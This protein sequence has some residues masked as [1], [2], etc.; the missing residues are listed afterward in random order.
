MSEHVE[1]LLKGLNYE[2][3][4]CTF[5]EVFRMTAFVKN[6]FTHNDK[7]NVY[8]KPRDG[9]PV[10]AQDHRQLR[11]ETN[12][13]SFRLGTTVTGDGL[14][15]EVKNFFDL[16]FG[17]DH[18]GFVKVTKLKSRT[19][20][21]MTILS[22]TLEHFWTPYGGSSHPLEAWRHLYS[23]LCTKARL[24]EKTKK[25]KTFPELFLRCRLLIQSLTG[26]VLAPVDGQHRFAA[27]IYYL[28]SVN[29][30]TQSNSR[31]S[32]TYKPRTEFANLF[33]TK[34]VDIN[35]LLVPVMNPKSYALVLPH[36][37]ESDSLKEYKSKNIEKMTRF[38]QK[39]STLYQEQASSAKARGWPEHLM[40]SIDKILFH[41]FGKNEDPKQVK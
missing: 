35:K 1:T 25:P 17:K 15:Q 16:I 41:S 19:E 21:A 4:E 27:I 11:Q 29:V 31:M 9:L 40:S 32:E 23:H 36:L 2:K 5:E 38:I 12:A 7:A 30:P 33:T 3:M 14:L 18:M 28:M 24:P 22:Y 8:D 39:V 37:S 10:I 13:D 26:L 20:Q 6:K 34:S